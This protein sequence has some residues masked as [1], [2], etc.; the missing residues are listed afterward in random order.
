MAAYVTAAELRAIVPN[1][2]RDAALADSGGGDT[3]D[4]GLLN[5]VLEAACEEVDA[6]IEGRVRLP[7]DKPAKK[8]RIAARYIALPGV[9][10][11]GAQAMA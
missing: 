7:V 11:V 9:W 4:P 3:A 8:L 10:P 6:L 1:Q 5:A 2:F